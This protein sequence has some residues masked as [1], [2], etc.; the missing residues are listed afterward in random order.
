MKRS[1]VLS[2][3]GV[4][5]A[6]DMHTRGGSQGL[7]LTDVAFDLS[8]EKITINVSVSVSVCVSVSVSVSGP[9][10]ACEPRPVDV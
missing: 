5:L 3:R 10:V 4:A 7:S 8:F 1:P 2:V 6:F 9:G